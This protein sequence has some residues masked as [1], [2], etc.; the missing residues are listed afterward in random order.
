VSLEEWWCYPPLRTQPPRRPGRMAQHEAEAMRCAVYDWRARAGARVCRVPAP[1]AEHAPAGGTHMLV[2]VRAAGV[3]PVDAKAVIGDKLAES[4]M[5]LCLRLMSALGRR[6]GFDYAGEVVWAP[7]GSRFARGDAVFGTNYQYPPQDWSGRFGGTLCDLALVRVDQAA[8]KPAALSWVDAAALP[9]VGVTA[10]QALE[11][12]R[13]VPGQRVLVLGAGGGVGHILTQ[14]AARMGCDVVGV[15][16]SAN[17]AFV[18]A[19]GAG[20]V[21]DYREGDVLE[22]VR[23]NAARHGA[24]DVVFDTVSSADARDQAS[25]YYDRIRSAGVA[26]LKQGAA[27]ADPH[28]YVVFGG[29]FR[30][31]AAAAL[32]RFAGINL[33]TSGFELFWINMMHSQRYL[34]RL[35][36]MAE[37]ADGLAR[38]GL[39]PLRPKVERT[40]PLSSRGVQAAFEALHPPPGASRQVSGKLVVDLGLAE[41]REPVQAEQQQEQE[42]QQKQKQQQEQQQQQQHP[43]P[44]SDERRPRPRDGR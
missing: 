39:A 30:S 2:R 17:V 26:V 43:L 20:A 12:H 1:L 3:N 5:Q 41:E 29:S 21:L 14:T 22:L 7:P 18:A 32:K 10:L 44:R 37:G 24:F 11:Q 9:L 27:A 28:N 40:L 35:A 8:R 16:G 19:C 34:E 25:Q 33:F 4:L 38:P 31:F 36:A 6:V 42:Q 13:V 23:A 15:C